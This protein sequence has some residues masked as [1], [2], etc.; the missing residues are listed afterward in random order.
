MAEQV[1]NKLKQDPRCVR[2]EYPERL[3]LSDL[4]KQLE[5]I[6]PVI[7]FHLLENI[8]R[9]RRKIILCRFDTAQQATEAKAINKW[10]TDSS[11]PVMSKTYTST[12]IWTQNF[13]NRTRKQRIISNTRIFCKL[14][15][16]IEEKQR[17]RS[18]F[19]HFMQFGPMVYHQI[20]MNS[21]GILAYGYVQYAK[22]EDASEAIEKSDSVYGA[23][24]A[25][26]RINKRD[27][28]L[29]TKYH[30]VCTKYITV[31]IY[32]L[33]DVTCRWQHEKK[34]LDARTEIDITNAK[35]NDLINVTITNHA[36]V[37]TPK[38]KEDEIIE[39]IT[40]EEINFIETLV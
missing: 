17:E 31:D 14:P 9:N 18:F 15:F 32:D 35:N 10:I 26:E 3:K 20:I 36:D 13:V 7:E 4:L 21:K 34:L 19:A 5:K 22:P 38:S 29:E 24:Y 16:D 33:H 37:N 30:W 23:K 40:S 8:A 1:E 27:Q 28:S 12:P 25:E 39:H 6:G 11:M 2:I